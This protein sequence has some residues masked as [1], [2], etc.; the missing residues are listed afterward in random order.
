[1]YYNP[2]HFGLAMV[3][4]VSWSEEAYQFD[5]TAVWRDAEGKLYWGDDSG[6]SCPSPFE[7]VNAL[8][9]LTTGTWSEL[10][11]HLLTRLTDMAGYAYRA[12]SEE[13]QARIL[14]QIVVLM[15]RIV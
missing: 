1:M 9:K 2:E 8:G 15:G 11:T 4:Q 14:G 3:G 12:P 13:E 6:C 7:E 10:N 5:L